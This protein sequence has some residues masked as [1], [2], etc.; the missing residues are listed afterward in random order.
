MAAH[1]IPTQISDDS[2]SAQSNPAPAAKNK[3]HSAFA[4]NN[5]KTIIQVQAQVHNVLDHIIPP[6]DEHAIQRQSNSR[7]SIPIFGI[8]LMLWCCNGYMQQCH[9][10]FS[11]LQFILFTN[12]FVEDCW[13][14]IAAMFHDNK[15][16]RARRANP[17]PP[18]CRRNSWP[19]PRRQKK[20]SHINLQIRPAPI[21]YRG[22]KG[23]S[24][25]NGGWYS[26]GG[27]GHGPPQWQSWNYLPWQRW[28]PWTYP[29]CPYPTSP[30]NRPNNG[31]KSQQEGILGAKPR[32]AFDANTTSPTDIE[33]ALNTLHL[34]Q[35]D[36]SW[37]M[38]IGVTSHMTS[39]QEC[40]SFGSTEDES[41][42]QLSREDDEMF[43]L[44]F[45]FSYVVQRVR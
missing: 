8:D 2:S 44:T 42:K 41:L 11:I 33:H 6:S 18:H 4:I 39:S 13:K 30:W 5:V 23:R 45:G 22:N 40:R 12:D 28:N 43:T 25:R 37:Y 26:N 19:K 36:P 20:I 34:A 1:A 35:P 7:L 32:Q 21:V 15:H 27:G 16:S 14:H 29:T 9:M 24:G 10:I 38:D 31:T 17:A 3:F